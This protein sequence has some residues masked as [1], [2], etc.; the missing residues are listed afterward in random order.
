MAK[1]KRN[2]SVLRSG[3]GYVAQ[4]GSEDEHGTRKLALIKG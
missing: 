4:Y 1:I 3:G 2:Q